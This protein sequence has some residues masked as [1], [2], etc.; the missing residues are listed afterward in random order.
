[1]VILQNDNQKNSFNLHHST[2][3]VSHC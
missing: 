2:S 3:A 1:M